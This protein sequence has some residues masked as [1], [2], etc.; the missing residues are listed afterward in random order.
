MLFCEINTE[1]PEMASRVVK[2]LTVMVW[3]CA[4]NRLAMASNAHNN[5]RFILNDIC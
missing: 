4:L 3:A 5:I 1:A 2:S